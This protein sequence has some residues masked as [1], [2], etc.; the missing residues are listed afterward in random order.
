MALKLSGQGLTCSLAISCF[1][2][3]FILSFK[4][5]ELLTARELKPELISIIAIAKVITDETT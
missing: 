1:K 2:G 5:E 4:Y 3:F